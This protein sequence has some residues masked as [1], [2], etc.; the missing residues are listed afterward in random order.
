MRLM[1]EL[2]KSDQ[3]SGQGEGHWRTYLRLSWERTTRHPGYTYA[4][5]AKITAPTSSSPAAGMSS[6]PSSRPWPRSGTC[7][8]VSWPCYRATATTSRLSRSLRR[9]TISS[10]NSRRNAGCAWPNRSGAPRLQVPHGHAEVEGATRRNR[11]STRWACC[12][13]TRAY[14]SHEARDSHGLVMT[15][16]HAGG[17]CGM[18]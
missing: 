2:L 12:G 15:A 10:A 8:T 13:W 11:A 3:D 18:P 16:L 14:A 17:S 7:R 5:F 6:A 1:F 4:D 9:S